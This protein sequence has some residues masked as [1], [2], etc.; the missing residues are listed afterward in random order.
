MAQTFKVY[1]PLLVIAALSV[2]GLFAPVIYSDVYGEILNES[3]TLYMPMVKSETVT[4]D[5]CNNPTILM[6]KMC[7]KEL[8]SVA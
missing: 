1:I 3:P 5:I 8:T 6:H 7:E 4:N 2:F